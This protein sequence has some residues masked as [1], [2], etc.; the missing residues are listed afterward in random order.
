VDRHAYQL[1]LNLASTKYCVN[2]N[3]DAYVLVF[4]F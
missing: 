2:F 1:E 3:S 4:E